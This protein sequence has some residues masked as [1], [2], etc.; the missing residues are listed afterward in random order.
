MSEKSE[1]VQATKEC[2]KKYHMTEQ[3]TKTIDRSLLNDKWDIVLSNILVKVGMGFGVGVITSVLFF[4]KRTFPVWLGI[5]FGL[6]RGYSEGDAIF[7][8]TAGLRAV[9]V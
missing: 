7:R 4:K 6:G 1:P 9:K 3:L 8:S 2:D 5:G